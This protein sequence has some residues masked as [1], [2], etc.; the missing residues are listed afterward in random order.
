MKEAGLDYYNH[1]L[2]TAPEDYARIVST[3]TYDERLDTLAHVREAGINVC[4]GGIVGMGET[5][6]HRAGLLQALANL[7]STRS[8]CRSTPW[9]RSRARRLAT[10]RRSTGS[11][12]CAPSLSPASCARARWCAWPPAAQQMSRELQALCL[13]AGANSIFIGDK[14]LTTPLPARMTIATCSPTSAC[15]RWVKARWEGWR[16]DPRRQNEIGAGIRPRRNRLGHDPPTAIFSSLCAWGAIASGR[17]FSRGR[18]GRR[19]PRRGAAA[20]GRSRS[21]HRDGD[22]GLLAS[23]ARRRS[24]YGSRQLHAG[25]RRYRRA[26]DRVR[27]VARR[28]GGRCRACR[29]HEGGDN[30]PVRGCISPLGL[31]RR[32][33]ARFSTSA[34][35]VRTLRPSSRRHDVS[36]AVALESKCSEICAQSRFIGFSS[37]RHHAPMSAAPRRAWRRAEVAMF[38]RVDFLCRQWCVAL[39]LAGFI[40]SVEPSA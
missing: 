14:L 16:P 37:S 15:A 28:P 27:A 33:R 6:S 29:F 12:S 26:E 2:D 9:F 23:G 1:N 32:L 21:W 40:L 4:C 20:G 25:R 39:A 36:G 3:R 34:S 38:G 31:A 18:P 30:G 5:R 8:P 24:S 13:L 35:S 17:G 22:R 7:P 10:A 11:S 19:L